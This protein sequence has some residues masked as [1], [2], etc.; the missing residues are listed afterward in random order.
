MIRQRCTPVLKKLM[1]HEF[2]WI[3]NQ[4]VDPVDLK[5]PDYFE[6]ITQPMDLGT[7]RKKLENGQ[8]R[9]VE[10][11]TAEVKLTFDNAIKYNGPQS[12]VTEVA[13]TMKKQFETL[14]KKAMKPIKDEELRKKNS[15]ACA[16]CHSEKLI[17][18]PTVYY[19]NGP[20]CNGQRIRRN[21]YYYTGGQNKYHW[22]HVC[23]GDMKDD[24]PNEMADCTLYVGEAVGGRLGGG[25]WERA[26][27]ATLGAVAARAFPAPRALLSSRPPVS[28]A[29][30][31]CPFP[32]SKRNPRVSR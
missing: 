15:E 24:M 13:K 26:R 10:E 25:T 16:L 9:D 12:E 17:F 22:C 1:D 3:F 14:W 2:G 32:T 8:Y 7:V 20:A 21:S 23:Y 4:P 5:L 18:E 28:L 11:F 19:C 6:T 30:P 29:A 27:R 31:C